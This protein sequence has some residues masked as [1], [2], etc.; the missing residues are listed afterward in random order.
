MLSH[1]LLVE[2]MEDLWIPLAIHNNKP[3]ADEEVLERYGEPAWN[4]PVV[5]FLDGEGV[6]LI[7]REDRVWTERGILAR[8]I[9]ALKATGGSVPA[10]LL[11]ALEELE[12]EGLERATFEMH[13]F[14]QGEARLGGLDGVA[15]TRAGWIDGREVVEVLY[16]PKRI[17]LTALL[18]EA[19][20]L[21][22]LDRVYLTGEEQLEAAR[23]RVGDRARL[24]EDRAADAK[25]SDRKYHLRQS[26]LRHVPLTPLQATRINADLA[27]ERAPEMRMT[28]RQRQLAVRI[29]TALEERPELFGGLERPEDV[30]ALAGY[31]EE[32]IE[33]IENGAPPR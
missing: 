8:M 14:W 21:E 28:P 9:Q 25:P 33:R 12:V 29:A 17:A 3:G 20:A 19:D 6:D 32:L 5:R 24:H 23:G 4:N 31:R 15:A 16:Q 27:H 7:P 30:Y 11:L 2:A 26:H 10:W 18:D 1:P 13:C 22:C